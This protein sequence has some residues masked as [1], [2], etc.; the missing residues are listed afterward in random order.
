MSLR[1]QIA[2][3]TRNPPITLKAEVSALLRQ[4]NLGS[5]MLVLDDKE[6]VLLLKAAIERE[7]SISTFAKRHGIERS[8]LSSLLNGKRPVSGPLVRALGLRRVY[9]PLQKRAPDGTNVIA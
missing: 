3:V 6:V 2:V 1:E 9:T 4:G 8:Y 7:G 5:R